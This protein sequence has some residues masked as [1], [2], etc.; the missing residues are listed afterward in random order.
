MFSIGAGIAAA[1][2]YGIS[3]FAGGRASSR[4]AVVQVLVLG[5]IIGAAILWALAYAFGEPLLAETR[6]P[7]ALASGASGALGVAALY[8]G[9]A[10]GHTAVVA[11]VSAVLAT[12]IPFFS[13]IAAEG[14]PGQ[15]AVLGIALGVAAIVC[16]SFAD[17][18]TARAGVI[19]GVVAGIGFG[20]YFI[21][22]AQ[23]SAG[24]ATYAP[25]AFSRTAALLIT[26]PWLLLRPGGRPTLAGVGFAVFACL[27]DVG[28][29]LS[30]YLGT[31][32]GRLDIVS[33]LASLYPAV[34]VLLAR[35]FLA[36]PIG[37][38]QRI[39]LGLSIASTMCVA[40]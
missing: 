8:Y 10:N 24:S 13:G 35:V 20:A 33:V 5:E 29:A 3:D 21:F 39:G 1:L 32:A 18:S 12:L 2:C 28:A 27:F 31:Q 40:L 38:M 37:R 4:M 14:M 16:T 19:A 9:I 22:V 36:E 17:G 34:T 15:L 7:T 23:V 25:L 11:P 6:I 30:F 26:V